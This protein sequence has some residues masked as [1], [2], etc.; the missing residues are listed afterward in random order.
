MA[1]L[2]VLADESR[3]LFSIY[4]EIDLRNMRRVTFWLFCPT[5]ELPKSLC[6]PDRVEWWNSETLTSALLIIGETQDTLHGNL[7]RASIERKP[8][9]TTSPQA[10]GAKRQ[11]A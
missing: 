11:T 5:S 3:Y 9:S 8:A 2:A 10:S 4:S 7:H 6:F 1:Q